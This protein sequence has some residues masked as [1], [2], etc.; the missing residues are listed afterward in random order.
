[1]LKTSF[2]QFTNKEPKQNH[3]KTIDVALQI[4]ISFSMNLGAC[5]IKMTNYN[6]LTAY[7]YNCKQLAE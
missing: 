6:L 4:R 5:F 1:M 2:T 7:W 3:N